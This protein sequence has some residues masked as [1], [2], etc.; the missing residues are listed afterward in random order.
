MAVLWICL[1]EWQRPLHYYG[2]VA[3]TV[4]EWETMDVRISFN[5]VIVALVEALRRQIQQNSIPFDL[6]PVHRKT[7]STTHQVTAVETTAP[8]TAGITR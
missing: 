2:Y 4:E 3:L 8:V 6:G 5:V 1:V 7:L